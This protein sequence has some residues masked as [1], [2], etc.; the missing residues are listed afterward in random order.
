MKSLLLKDF[1]FIKRQ[2]SIFIAYVGIM[3]LGFGIYKLLE[4]SILIDFKK[5]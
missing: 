1:Y 4:S 3:A 2:L 5:C